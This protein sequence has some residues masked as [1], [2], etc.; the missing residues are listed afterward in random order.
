MR[1]WLVFMSMK[2]LSRQVDL[3]SIKAR[4]KRVRKKRFIIFG[5]IIL[6]LAVLGGFAVSRVGLIR[7]IL[8]PVSF[9]ARL[10]NPI[11]LKEADGRVNVLVLGLDTRGG[12]G[13]MNTDTI[14][15]GSF[16]L[17]EG[18]PT[19][20][21]IPRDLWLNLSPYGYGRINSAYSR[22]GL[23]GGKLSEEEGITFAKEKV[24]EI[25]GIEIPYWALVDFEGFARIID[26]LDGIEV[27][28]ERTFDDYAYPVPGKENATPLSTRYEHLHFDA[29]CQNMDGETA[30]KYARSRSGTN[31][32]GSDFARVRRQQRVISGVRD[33]VLSINLLLNPG[34]L[35]NLYKQ[36]TDSVKT[37]ASLGE[38]QRALEIASKF[39]DLSE[40]DS[41]IL[42]PDSKLVYHP[43]SALYGGAYV[44]V[45]Q[46]GN[47]EGIH[48]AVQK[49]LYKAEEENQQ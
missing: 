10:I 13:L 19:L 25:L 17:L 15:V 4:K 30:L 21:S 38:V 1:V 35:A 45:P 28:V 22:G 23:S 24:S 29:G 11:Q 31:S 8:A 46:G 39:E 3:D 40:V 42:D 33:K 2:Y 14:L 16:S 37:N 27:C 47:F 36:I 6:L 44:L 32:E 34:K 26:T 49:L 43:N 9:V 20:I 48:T 7:S 5:L 12:G 41:L 18:D